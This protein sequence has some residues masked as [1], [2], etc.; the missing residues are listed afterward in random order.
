MDGITKELRARG[1]EGAMD[2]HIS[3][4]GLLG[5]GAFTTRVWAANGYGISLAVRWDKGVRAT[6]EVWETFGPEIA[7]IGDNGLMNGWSFARCPEITGAADVVMRVGD[8]D[9]VR[10]VWDKVRALPQYRPVQ[11]GA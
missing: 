4:S 3:D 2:V 7:V 6:G 9:D 10:E 5:L 1:L 11:E 8:I